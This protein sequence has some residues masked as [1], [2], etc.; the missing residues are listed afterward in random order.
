MSIAADSVFV[1][2]TDL[3][4]TD[5]EDAVVFLDVESGDYLRLSGTALSVWGGLKTPCTLENL[6]GLLSDEYGIDRE[7]CRR[8]TE[9]FLAELVRAKLVVEAVREGA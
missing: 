9:P 5:L 3:P 4:F 6:V 8:D 2:N 1:R 7:T